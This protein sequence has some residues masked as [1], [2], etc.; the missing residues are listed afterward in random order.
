MPAGRIAVRLF[1]VPTCYW[2]IRPDGV[3]GMNAGLLVGRQTMAARTDR[4][5]FF[6]FVVGV[7]YREFWG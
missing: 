6:G 3:T 1:R 4:K 7:L 2:P 5:P